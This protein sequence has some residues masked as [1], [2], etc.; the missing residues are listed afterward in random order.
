[1]QKNIFEK[2]ITKNFILKKYWRNIDKQIL[3]S[4]TLLF[5]L[6]VF[7]S[8]SS[9]SILADERIDREY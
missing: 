1:M 6:G 2:L 3:L 9:T 8:F 5:I 4:F 7:F